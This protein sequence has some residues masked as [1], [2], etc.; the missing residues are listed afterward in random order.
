MA[1]KIDFGFKTF[2]VEDAE[3]NIVGQIRFNPSDPGFVARWDELKKA[4]EK[5]ADTPPASPEALG[6]MDAEIKRLMDAAFAA[7][8]ADV[9]FGGL[10]AFCLCGDGRY[11]IS[12]VL[13]ALQPVLVQEITAA[14]KASRERM[15]K[16]TAAYEG[17]LAGLAP[18]Q[19]AN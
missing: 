5:M 18:G 11:L 2:D 15:A 19:A 10:S 16:H 7:P 13:D 1:L 9:L 12:N 14:Q 4:V 3:G 17:S 6:A 8:C